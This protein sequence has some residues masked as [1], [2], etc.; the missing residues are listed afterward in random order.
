MFEGGDGR[1]S[2]ARSVSH[3]PSHHDG[4]GRNPLQAP[5]ATR[6]DTPVN[7]LDPKPPRR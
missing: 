1:S 3:G 7:S 6:I 2:M 4:M 5:P